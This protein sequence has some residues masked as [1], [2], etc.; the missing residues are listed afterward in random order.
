MID[1]DL[2]ASMLA[3]GETRNLTRASRALGVSQPA[4][5]ERLRRL[6]DQLG[7]PLYE[8]RGRELALTAAGVRV[9][10]FAREERDRHAALLAELRGEPAPTC[11]ALAAGEGAYLYL[12]GP[13]LARL[14]QLP[15]IDLQVHT[16]GAPSAIEAV[17]GGRI[18]LAVA[19]LDIAPPGIDAEPLLV[20]PT[21]VAL[22]AR[23]PAAK[24]RTVRL[25]QL[26]D[27]RWILAPEGQMHRAFVSR[28]IARTGAAPAGVI[29]A[30]G[31]PLMLGFVAHGLG[32]A[33]VN[34]SCLPPAGVVLRPLPELAKVTYQLLTR[35][36]RQLSPEAQ[37]V[38][39]EIKRACRR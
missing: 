4:L 35:Q 32:I 18:H 17:R 24:Q 34:G 38:A 5:F 33:I 19:A 28:A 16:L 2:L 36:R 1:G 6:S 25:A 3:F 7:E 39:A 31:W 22:P 9:L 15:S 20:T 21:C 11:V 8:R 29:E 14:A 26:R 30:D 23:H 12:L 10:A 13:A 37:Q 27:A